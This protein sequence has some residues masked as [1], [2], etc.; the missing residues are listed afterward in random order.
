ME[1]PGLEH[2]SDD[3]VRVTKH[4]GG[5]KHCPFAQGTP[6]TLYRNEV[7]GQ[8]SQEAENKTL[9]IAWNTASA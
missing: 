1:T 2:L 5:L 3:K 4:P 6:Q 9:E 7:T 8:A